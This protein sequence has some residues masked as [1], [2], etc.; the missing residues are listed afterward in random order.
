MKSLYKDVMI[1]DAYRLARQGI[2]E[3]KIAE[4]LNISK[5]TL[6]SW[7]NKKKAFA[8]ALKEGRKEF[9]GKGKNAITLQNHIFKRLSPNVKKTWKKLN[10]MQKEREGF[11]KIEAMLEKKGKYVRQ[12]LFVY[13]WTSA[14]FNLIA[15]LRKV[16]IPRATFDQWRKTDKGFASVVNEIDKY[17]KDFFEQHLINLVVGGSESATLFVNKTY[18]SD[19]YQDPKKIVD[20]NLS[21]SLQVNTT[22]LGDLD[23]T[24]KQRILLLKAIRKN[25]QSISNIEENNQE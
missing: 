3:N 24:K 6:D 12:S 22:C 17:K 15:A 14:N 7:V 20:V 16:N 21:G 25:K 5:P 1:L 18:N 23:L 11:G 19:R 9:H 8:Y 13:A 4:I 2:K 10:R